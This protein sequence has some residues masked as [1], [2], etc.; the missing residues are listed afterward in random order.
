MKKIHQEKIYLYG[1]NALI[2]ALLS[3]P[4][5]IQKVFLSPKMMSD[6]EIMSKLKKFHL[7]PLGLKNGEGDAKV[8]ADTVHQGVIAV[9]NPQKLL[10]PLDTALNRIKDSGII[11]PSIVVLGELQDPHNVGAII[12][13]AV[14]FG[15]SMVILP[16]HNQAPITGTVIKT[17]VGMVF[18]IPIVQVGN[19]NMT[20]RT[21]KEKG[22]WVYGLAMDGDS[23]LSKT[24]FDTPVVFVVGNEGT[25]IR[26]KTLE[27][28]DIKISIPID[29]L[30]ESLNAATAASVVLYDWYSKR[31]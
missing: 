28:C 25:G 11:N 5:I 15:A 17:S 26:E 10:T 30:C 12:R 8:G 19:I 4:D 13:S 3:Q 9:I 27:L 23:T 18:K 2:E 24:V 6:V 21:L 1:K 31:A 22:Y 7:T 29:P 20:L 16:E 14:A